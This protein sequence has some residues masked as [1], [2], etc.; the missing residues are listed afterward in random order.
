MK[1]SGSK[2]NFNQSTARR[3]SNST[4]D[5][6]MTLGKYKDY[7]KGIIDKGNRMNNQSSILKNGENYY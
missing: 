6:K 2:V 4:L 5:K 7:D 1:L 3:I